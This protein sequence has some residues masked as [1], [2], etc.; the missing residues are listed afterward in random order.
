MKISIVILYIIVQIL[1]VLVEKIKTSLSAYKNS[2]ELILINDFSSDNS[3]EVIKNLKNT[4][5]FIKGINLK[6][7]YGQHSAIFCGLKYCKG[8]FIFCM[9]DDMQ[10][11]PAHLDNMLR[12]LI[13]N[14]VCYVKYLKREHNFFKIFV[15]KLNIIS[16][17]LMNKSY[18]I[19]TSSFKCFKKK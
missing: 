5:I 16:S 9:D 13:D 3:W 19:Y 10:H 11:D 15:N 14:E 18:K 12:E 6:K 17:F 8:E 1:E 4:N 7:N 2:F